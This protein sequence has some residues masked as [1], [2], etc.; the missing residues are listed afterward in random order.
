MHQK[1]E[2]NQALTHFGYFLHEHLPKFGK[3]GKIHN[4]KRGKPAHYITTPSQGALVATCW[5]KNWKKEKEE[6][7]GKAIEIWYGNDCT[8]EV[9]AS[10]SAV[11]VLYSW[12]HKLGNRFSRTQSWTT[13]VV[14]EGNQK[15]SEATHIHVIGT[16]QEIREL[17]FQLIL[18]ASFCFVCVLSVHI[19]NLK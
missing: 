2:N 18:P 16:W 3:N 14:N 4:T 1:G 9:S 17:L 5:K 19:S 10:F 8:I 13:V 12:S 15:F 11:I 6:R 7:C